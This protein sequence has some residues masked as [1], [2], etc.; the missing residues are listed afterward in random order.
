MGDNWTKCGTILFNSRESDRILISRPL[1]QWGFQYEGQG[2]EQSFHIQVPIFYLQF[3]LRANTRALNLESH[4]P[5][6]HGYD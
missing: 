6:G 4:G 2:K 5:H 1:H 3:I